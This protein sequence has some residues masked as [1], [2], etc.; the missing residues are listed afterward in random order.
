MNKDDEY[1][2]TGREG[3][4]T[5][6][7][8]LSVRSRMIPSVAPLNRPYAHRL[9]GM[10]LRT[11]CGAASSIVGN[12]LVLDFLSYVYKSL[13]YVVAGLRGGLEEFHPVL[14]SKGF[15]LLC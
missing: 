7:A 4:F 10:R 15:T 12:L 3:S 11:L 1:N 13:L 6:A 2:T 5:A 9:L 8:A 14:S